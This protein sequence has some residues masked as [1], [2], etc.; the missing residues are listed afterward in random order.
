MVPASRRE[1][2][3]DHGMTWIRTGLRSI[4]GITLVVLMVLFVGIRTVD[5]VPVT[6]VPIPEMAHAPALHLPPLSAAISTATPK[7][8]TVSVS[9]GMVTIASDT[10]LVAT[11]STLQATQTAI[12]GM[13]I[14][15]NLSIPPAIPEPAV[16]P[17]GTVP[18]TAVPLLPTM[19]PQTAFPPP[20]SVHQQPLVGIQV[21]HWQTED[22]PDELAHLRNS[23]GVTYEDRSE[24][25][26][27]Y[28]V[29]SQVRLFLEAG[30][31]TVDLI[32][33]TVPPGYAADAF[34]SIH[35]DGGYPADE[36]IRHGWKMAAPFLASPASLHL[37]SA[38][39]H[40]Y[41]QGVALPEDDEN[42]TDRMRFY[43]AF[44]YYRYTHAIA[45]TTPAI[46]IE[47]GYLTHPVDRAVLLEQPDALA[48][49]IANGILRYVRERD[50]DDLAA[51]YPPRF[52]LVRPATTADLRRA[53]RA[54]ARLI[55]TLTSADMLIPVDLSESW[56]QVLV[57]G[58]WEVGWV[59]ANTVTTIGE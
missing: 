11:A 54:S 21:G 26:I 7:Y 31:V 29:A 59:P 13:D 47:M 22:R 57:Q 4:I 23:Y 53:P 2:H 34:V 8:A 12:A 14:Q 19:P 9:D 25:Q 35:A 48:Q 37:L 55:T 42:I 5:D 46:I 52:P 49:A 58:S 16:A 10:D 39:S 30:G 41:R 32:P 3:R 20:A 18:L 45:P 1:S 27:N 50:P 28:Q 33:A 51:L 6:S 24:V 40:E 44:N 15:S 38:V 56:Y 17:S 43:H 36:H